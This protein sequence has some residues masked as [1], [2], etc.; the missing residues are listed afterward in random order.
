MT[1][2]CE[3]YNSGKESVCSDILL[4]PRQP[5]SIVAE[6]PKQEKR[7]REKKNGGRLA[8]KQ[9]AWTENVQVLVQ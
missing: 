3:W 1:D 5:G 8:L 6:M 7:E 4:C 9:M 2:S